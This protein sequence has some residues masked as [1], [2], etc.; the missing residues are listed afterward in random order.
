MTD[1]TCSADGLVK[2]PNTG[3]KYFQPAVSARP[4]ISPLRPETSPRRD[5]SIIGWT[6]KPSVKVIP[7]RETSPVVRKKS[8]DLSYLVTDGSGVKRTHQEVYRDLM[9]KDA[10]RQER[11]K[12]AQMLAEV[13][14]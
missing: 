10:E 3:L 12:S 11:R 13:S 5:G 9:R 8:S 6:E 2:D 7:V 14:Y 1:Y 4:S